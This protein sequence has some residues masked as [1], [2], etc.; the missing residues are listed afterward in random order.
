MDGAELKFRAT[1]ALRTRVVRAKTALRSPEWQREA[2]RLTPL[3]GIVGARDAL[4]RHDWLGAHRALAAHFA[5]RRALFPLDPRTLPALASRVATVFGTGDAQRRA[6]DVLAGRYDLLG[7]RGVNVGSPP[8]WHRDPVHG[9]VAPMSFWDA[10]PYLDPR[11][12]DHKITWE[13][14]RHQHF[15]A[16]GRAYA[17]TGDRRYYR[18][19]VTQ[20]IDW[21]RRNP[22]L[23]GTNW[24]SM[25]ELAFRCLS[26]TWALHFFAGA[27]AEDAE[28]WTVELLLAL[29]RQLAHVE[30]NLSLYFSPNT[31]L[32]GEALALYVAGRVLPELPGSAGRAAIGRRILLQ[33][34]DRQVLADGAHAERSTHYHR[35]STDFYL[36]AFNVA[37]ASGDPHA[38]AFRE[39]AL[40]QARFLRAI[41]DDNGRIPLIGDDDGG[42]LFPIG[43]RSP[44]DC[45]DTL[46]TAAVLLSEPS[47]AVRA[48]P[49]ETYWLCGSHPDL[50]RFTAHRWTPPPLRPGAG[51]YC[52][53]RNGRGDH[54]VFDC[55]AHGYLNGGHAHADALS[56]VL[57]V[58]GRPLLVDPG[59]ATYTMDRAVR[60][61]FRSTA[62]HNTLVLDGRSQS[63]PAGP[64]HWSSHAD[65]CCT[66]SESTADR[67]VAVGQH[68]GYTP[69]VHS[70]E[71][72]S[73]H[74]RGW[75][76]VDRV[77]GPGVVTAAAMW[78]FHPDWSLVRF[79]DGQAILQHTDGTCFVFTSSVPLRVATAPGLDEY[80]PEYGRIE[81]ALC[82]EA[83]ISAPTPI[84]IVTV[85]PADGT[86]T[87]AH[88]LASA[89]NT[90]PAPRNPA[91]RT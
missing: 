50:E 88:E 59:T 61:R 84:T 83:S 33:E 69:H 75:T 42:Q 35:Y 21:I 13:L 17:L 46:A 3:P 4:A 34:A 40:R 80:A 10:V 22:P 91:P 72:T 49:E 87:T 45:A 51:G 74:G 30:E 57:T 64:F 73:V 2:L 43:G 68:D 66:R 15:L 85:I 16:L 11:Y 48:L 31:H 81:R 5:R 8:D 54:L 26:W 47:L 39:P 27:A 56:I 77:E 1:A 38:S 24:A 67:D 53:S 52:V 90:I 55:G 60:D 89:V 6:E 44:A 41:A 63:A 23:L 82:L 62:M 58:A 18:E 79:E 36:L 86:E 32:T 19:F 29:D 25:L 14:N 28:P 20:L 12:G 71:V 37:R 76:I 7:Y 78:H 9:L 70:R 65:A